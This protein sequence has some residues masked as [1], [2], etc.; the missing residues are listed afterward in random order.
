MPVY[1]KSEIR[2]INIKF[3]SFG[4]TREQSIQINSKKNFKRNLSAKL[5]HKKV[6]R[7]KL[8]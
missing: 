6:K 1:K 4:Y 8:T 2:R 5:L 7:A 3:Y